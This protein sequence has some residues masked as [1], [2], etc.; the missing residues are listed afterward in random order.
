MTLSI[1]QRQPEL[2][3]FTAGQ[4]I[5]SLGQPADLMYGIVEGMVELRINGSTVETIGPS[6]IFGIG[7]LIEDGIRPYT[8][9]AATDCKLAFLD[10]RRFLF[11]VQE[12]PTFSLLVMKSYSARIARLTKFELERLQSAPVTSL[13]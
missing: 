3:E 8:A 6:E 13:G 4:E 7:A 5:F 10:E 11:A 12:T 2:K 1:F 9:I